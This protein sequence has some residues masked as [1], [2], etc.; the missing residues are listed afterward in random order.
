MANLLAWSATRTK[1]DKSAS[2]DQCLRDS[3]L[4]RMTISRLRGTA[5][6]LQIPPP[7]RQRRAFGMTMSFVNFKLAKNNPNHLE[8][9]A[10]TLPL[11]ISPSAATQ[12]SQN[13][14]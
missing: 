14:G 4:E 9:P 3:E 10:E 6:Q 13:V 5:R 2:V 8:L 11:S 12:R 1:S 7:A